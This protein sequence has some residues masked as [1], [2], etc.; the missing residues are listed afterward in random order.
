MVKHNAN[1]CM[2]KQ[3]K[4]NIS[5]QYNHVCYEYQAI[6]NIVETIIVFGPNNQTQVKT[7]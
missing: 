2:K 4:M 6:A 5:L 7:D 1:E 3:M